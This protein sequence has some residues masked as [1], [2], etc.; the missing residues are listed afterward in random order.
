MGLNLREPWPSRMWPWMWIL[1]PSQKNLYKDIML[2]N[3]ENF[4]SVAQ[5]NV[6]NSVVGLSLLRCQMLWVPESARKVIK[7]Q[8]HKIGSKIQGPECLKPYNIEKERDILF[9]TWVKDFGF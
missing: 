2:E 1:K 7:A 9:H 6:A 4:L 8:A 5:Y 3:H